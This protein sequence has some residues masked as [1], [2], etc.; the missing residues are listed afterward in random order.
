MQHNEIQHPDIVLA[1]KGRLSP[2]PHTEQCQVTTF[3]FLHVG[4]DPYV[5]FFVQSIQHSN[6]EAR[7]IQVTD[8]RTDQI[9]GVDEIYRYDSD[10][11]KLMTFRLEAF[12]KLGL[13]DPAIYL[14]TDM[15]VLSE[16][17]AEEILGSVDV[18]CCE[19]SF[20][21]NA[22]I[23]TAFRG[24][25]LWEYRNKTLGE[26]Y[27]ILAAFTVSRNF[28]FWA[29]C[30]DRLLNLDK[31]FFLWYGDQEAIRD[32]AKSG[33]YKLGYVPEAKFACLPEHMQGLDP[34]VLH[35]KGSQRKA[36]MEEAWKS[37]AG[38]SAHVTNVI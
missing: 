9:D 38:S 1:S 15:L 29:S 27:P 12:T 21:R 17:S 30:Y 28:E 23:N 25:N 26:V 11:S 24:M 31:K 7:L 35:F 2:R 18:A 6:P 22:I 4:P 16:L 3:V 13:Q 8:A 36:W 19:R 10:A 37:I 5:Q 34:Y 14:D 33:Q 32:V 20:G